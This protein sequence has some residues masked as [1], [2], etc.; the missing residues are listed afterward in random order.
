MDIHWLV[1]ASEAREQRVL[2]VLGQKNLRRYG[3]YRHYEWIDS[4]VYA[5]KHVSEYGVE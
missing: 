3:V 4:H 2:I 5:L 1:E